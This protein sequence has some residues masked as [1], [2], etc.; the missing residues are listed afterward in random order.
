MEKSGEVLVAGFSAVI[1]FVA[2]GTG[3]YQYY[4]SQVWKKSEFAAAQLQRL[5]DDPTLALCCVFLDWGAR[6][7]AVPKEYSVFT[8]DNQT[9]FVHDWNNFKAAMQPEYQ[10]ANF[11]FPLVLYRD[12]FDQFFV[13]LDRI[14][15]Y[16]A[17]GLF[18]VEDVYPL[19]YWLGELKASRYLES[20][21]KHVFLTFIEHYHYWG[22]KSLMKKFDDY[23]RAVAAG[24]KPRLEPK[25]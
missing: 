17:I 15:H 8:S 4:R 9:S 23:E 7:I 13:Y 5:T 2:L 11:Q 3:L 16:I 21:D 20:K 19:S 14:N 22:V 1:G 24:M 10:E 12:S 18:K 25:N 6:R